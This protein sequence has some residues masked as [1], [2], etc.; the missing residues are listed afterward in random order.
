MRLFG[1]SQ[2]REKRGA[3]HISPLSSLGFLFLK[4]VGFHLMV[5]RVPKGPLRPLMSGSSLGEPCGF[6]DFP[7]TK[8]SNFISRNSTLSQVHYKNVKS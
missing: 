5:L 1:H 3:I 4:N 7:K 8:T 2:G 6:V